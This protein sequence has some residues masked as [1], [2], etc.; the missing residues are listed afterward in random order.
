MDGLKI[1]F[2]NESPIDA[3]LISICKTVAP[4]FYKT[5]HSPNMITTYSFIFELLSIYNLYNKNIK[6]FILTYI[7][8]YFF[9]CLDGYYARKYNM[10]TKIGDNYDHITDNITNLCIILIVLFQYKKKLSITI[11]L[12]FIIISYLMMTQLGCQQLIYKD[13]NNIKIIESL[14]NL[15]GMCFGNPN[16]S[17]KFTKYF[18]PGFYNLAVIILIIYLSN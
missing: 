17:I 10:I 16:D 3:G 8:A 6:S 15:Q 2:E 12:I 7:I 11:I 1:N 5:G 9:D 18:G 4:L 14:D 13:K